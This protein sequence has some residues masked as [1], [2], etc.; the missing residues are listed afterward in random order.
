MFLLLLS[1]TPS[2]LQDPMEVINEHGADALRLY[3]INS[4]VVRGETLKFSKAGV[5]AVIKDVF[6]PWYNAYRWVSVSWLTLIDELS[7]ANRHVIC[8]SAA[9]QPPSYG[10]GPG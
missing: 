5:F 4:P 9:T 8:W 2:A 10:G 1:C 7:A 3:L 6:L